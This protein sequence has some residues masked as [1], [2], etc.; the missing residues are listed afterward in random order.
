MIIKEITDKLKVE[1]SDGLFP[2]EKIVRFNTVAGKQQSMFVS[3]RIVD[4]KESTVNV[5]ILYSGKG[6]VLIQIGNESS[7][8]DKNLIIKKDKI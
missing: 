4:E 5:D 8:V 3:S 1:I 6:G 7:I 2:N